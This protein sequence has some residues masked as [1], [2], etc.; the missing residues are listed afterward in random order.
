MQTAGGQE[1]ESL[2][3]VKSLRRVPTVAPKVLRVTDCTPL[4][5]GAKWS[6]PLPTP[7]CNPHGPTHYLRTGRGRDRSLVT[8]DGRHCVR[9]RAREPLYFVKRLI[10]AEWT[11]FPWAAA[12]RTLSSSCVNGGERSIQR[13][14]TLMAATWHRGAVAASRQCSCELAAIVRVPRRAIGEDT[15]SESHRL[16]RFGSIQSARLFS[17]LALL[18]GTLRRRSVVRVRC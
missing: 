11:A 2:A 17:E 7:G 8:C 9:S 1:L 10:A 14:E 12:E 13:W 4:V 18:R 15:M 6:K 3:K 16:W 5:R